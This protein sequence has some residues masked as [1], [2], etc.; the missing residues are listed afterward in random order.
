MAPLLALVLILSL[1]PAC[2]GG[3][4][5]GSAA[6]AAAG[7][8]VEV[9]GTVIPAEPRR[10]LSASAS[11]TEILYALGAGAEIVATD[12]FSNFPAEAAATPKVDAFNLGVES[13]AAFAPDLVI[14]SYDPGDLRAGLA[15]LGIPTLLFAPPTT[16]E[17]AFGQM[18]ALGRAAG[19]EQEAAALV[20]GLRS[21]VDRLAAARPAGSPPLTYY[22][23]LDPTL[24]SLTSG[25]FVG[26]LLALLGLESIAD[27]ADAAGTGFPQLSAEYILSSDPDFIF[28][29]DTRCC[30]QSVE[31]VAARPGWGAL[32]AVAGGRVVELDDDV[33][34]R[35]GP[36]LIDLLAAVAGAIDEGGG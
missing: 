6:T 32:Q 7:F 18:T 36:R 3:T 5:G 24:Y 15:A 2:G 33:A 31:T 10:I 1:V 34:S 22:Y 13:V 35:W 19:R 8:P 21:E 27:A 16:L 14:L 17:D 25:T 30:G 4:E 9:A 29:A 26:S 20:A 12:Q 11:H 23:E 28:L